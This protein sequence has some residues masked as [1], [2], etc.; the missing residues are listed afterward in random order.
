MKV[1]KEGIKPFLAGL[2][3][4]AGQVSRTFFGYLLD[5]FKRNAEEVAKGIPERILEPVKAKIIEVAAE[6][7]SGEEKMKKVKEYA[8]QLLGETAKSISGYILDTFLQN[9]VLDLK[10]KGFSE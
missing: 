4:K 6:N 10:K 3:K 8:K 5:L 2:F 1:W 7:I 9:L